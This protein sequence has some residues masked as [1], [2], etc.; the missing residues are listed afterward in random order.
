MEAQGRKSVQVTWE[1][2]LCRIH[3]T[4]WFLVG[5]MAGMLAGMGRS[6]AGPPVEPV[7]LKLESVCLHEAL[8]EASQRFGISFV[9]TGCAGA[10]KPL[11]VTA[12]SVEA[13]LLQ[14]AQTFGARATYLGELWV[15]DGE[16]HPERLPLHRLLAEVYPEI[17]ALLGPL[18]EEAEAQKVATEL[19][20]QAG[21]LQQQATAALQQEWEQMNI[22]AG[23]EEADTVIL[24][25]YELKAGPGK[26]AV[27]HWLLAQC[28][29]SL[30][31]YGTEEL[32]QWDQRYVLHADMR[33]GGMVYVTRIGE[34][35]WRYPVCPRQ[36]ELVDMGIPVDSPF[37]LLCLH[38]APEKAARWSVLLTSAVTVESDSTV[39]EALQS[40]SKGLPISLEA[41]SDWQKQH[42]CAHLQGIPLWGAL[43]AVS[44]ATGRRW[45]P[46]CDAAR[47]RFSEPADL[48]TKVFAGLTPE[49]RL[50]WLYDEAVRRGMQVMAP[51]LFAALS[52]D[53]REKLQ[54]GQTVP[55]T[56]LSE[57][58]LRWME[59]LY[60]ANIIGPTLRTNLQRLAQ[61]VPLSAVRGAFQ[62]QGTQVRASVIMS[63]DGLQG[64]TALFLGE[65]PKGPYAPLTEIAISGPQRVRQLAFLYGDHPGYGYGTRTHTPSRLIINRKPWGKLVGT[66]VK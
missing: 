45:E 23:P 59:R 17:R 31:L 46:L 47:Y 30:L 39:G 36:P 20:K 38:L 5:L 64:E 26:D 27:H 56:D 58:A 35:E 42:L 13:L 40:L 11:D 14:V 57:A 48:E 19:F 29:A 66:T 15:V 60:R 49:E 44:I 8:R 43:H 28:L 37:A 10:R 62:V 4:T 25:P 21:S 53:Q 2:S 61:I 50:L 41:D 63:E 52:P 18:A 24:V 54:A 32:P 55:V 9:S 33:P 22:P 1:Q 6:D 7:T 3:G 12:A 34:G 16:E 65:V 51:H